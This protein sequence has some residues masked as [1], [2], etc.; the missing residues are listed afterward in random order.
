AMLI[1]WQLLDKISYPTKK[2]FAKD[3]LIVA[4]NL[5]V[6]SRLSVL[7]PAGEA[8]YYDAFNV[9]PLGLREQ[10]RQAKVIVRNWHTLAWDTE[11]KL[12]KKRSVDKRGAKSD[13]AYAREILGEL[14][15]SK[16]FIVIND[17]AHHAWRMPT[18][19]KLSRDEKK[20]AEEA[21]I[22]IGGLDRL[23]KARGI[24]TVY[25][26]SATPFIPSGKNSSSEN[27]FSWI[28]SDFGLT[29][30]IE[31]GLVKTP[32]VVIRDDGQLGADYKSQFYHLYNDAAVKSS[33]NKKGA[34][35]SEALPTLVENAYAL[36]GQDWKETAK[37]WRAAGHKIPPV[38]ISVANQTETAARIKYAFDHKNILIEE[39]CNAEKTLHIDSKVLESAETFI[40]EGNTETKTSDDAE[41]EDAPTRKLSKKDL[42]LRLRQT[43]DTIGREGELGEQ[44]QHVI[45]VGMLTEGWDCLDS[46][47]E[48]L[49]HQGWK[50]IGQ[51]I[52]GEFVYSL[53]LKTEKLE[54]VPIL[55]YGERYV[56]PNEKMVR[57]KS[58]QVDIRVTEGH[59]FYFK[60]R[61]PR[62]GGALCKNILTL[63]AGELARRKSSYALPLAAETKNEFTGLPLTD[64]EIRLIAWF[65]TD[66]GFS[67]YKVAISQSKF[68]HY[69]IRD[70]LN[71]INLDFS[72]SL[73]N[74]GKGAYPN[75]KPVHV[76]RIPKGTHT[77]TLQ[78][79]GWYTYD[80]YL[81]KT[82][83]QSLHAMTRRQFLVFWDELLKGDGERQN[84]KSGWLWC[85]L[86]EQADAY[87]QM[88]VE[89]GLSASY[90][91][92]TLESGKVM[93]RVSVRDKQWLI[94]EPSDT[95]AT[96]ITLE[97]AQ[98]LETVWC[99]RNQN[100]TIVTRRNGKIVIL[101]NCQTVTHIMGL[102]AF[103]SQL[104]C[105]QVVGRGLRRTS[106][107]V[108]P[109]TGL[110]SPEYVNIFGV[111]FAF[112]PHESPTGSEV[113]P[114]APKQRIQPL[115]EK[116]EFEIRFPNVLR[117]EN[118]FKP[119][120]KLDLDKIETLT[121]DAYDTRELA[122]LA[123][124][125]DGR[126]DVTRLSEI[127]LETLY[128]QVRLQSSIF[129]ATL[130]I[131]KQIQP[132]W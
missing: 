12:S 125:I 33:L 69:E 59:R 113:K 53:N 89:R 35:E 43:V 37:V 87:T 95:R 65:M 104:L 120:L 121:L 100:S 124:V 97:D 30:A 25:D 56:R 3:F 126:H 42:A 21:T 98:P 75:S 17:E 131:Y 118:K 66:G 34:S 92:R 57:L 16:N 107:D 76:F 84:H 117:I 88:A 14:A 90:S 62:A 83:A 91:Q 79:N 123:P 116:L 60:Y 46:K 61:N 70:L 24:Q 20:D 2:G 55:D 80:K 77:G 73:V 115:A 122:E 45:S 15:N 101:G 41:T 68:Y 54:T 86:K 78:R 38:M 119:V 49:T 128:S 58:Q 74:P 13:E 111:P 9:V 5:T 67:N 4:P 28:V 23:N 93:Y 94:S 27:L 22:W 18:D 132:D 19:V 39:L 26:F 108:D 72:E 31:S 103:S 96:K 105:E 11:E 51:I 64:D 48:I 6:R 114:T 7:V 81:D 40:E 102:R 8:N 47:T 32:R 110:F 82:V 36:L 85:D 130:D 63:T 109:E 50:G 106:Y 99:I 71:R 1:V 52:V 129:R 112:M 44:I 10:L 29:E 127:D